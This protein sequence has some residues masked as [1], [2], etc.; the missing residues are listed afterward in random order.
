MWK[1][2]TLIANYAKLL[3]AC[4]DI[5]D[6]GAARKI[7]ELLNSTAIKLWFRYF[8]ALIVETEQAS[9]LPEPSKTS[10]EKNASSKASSV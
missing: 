8:T 2:A 9:S 6:A 3:Q 7:V 1:G 5:G 10:V 4:A